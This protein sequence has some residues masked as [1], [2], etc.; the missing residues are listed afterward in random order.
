M[1]EQYMVRPASGNEGWLFFKLTPEKG[2]EL[3]CIGHVRM[4]FGHG[5]KEFW[6]TWHPHGPE[7]WNSTEFKAELT[8][9]VDTLRENVLKDL[10][11]MKAYCH[12]NGGGINGGWSQNY[13]YIVETD[14]YMYCLRCNPMPGDYQA[15]LTC[16]DR[17]VQEMNRTAMLRTITQDELEVMY[18]KHILFNHGEGGEKADFTNC[19]LTN[20]DLQFMQLNGA[21]FDDALL[22]NVKMGSAGVCFGSF[23]KTRFVQCKMEGIYAEEANFSG[24]SFQDCNMQ[25]G[26]YT[27]SNFAN[28]KF[29][30]TELWMADLPLCCIEGSSI[31]QN[32]TSGLNLSGATMKE[33][34][35]IMGGMV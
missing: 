5:G 27:H 31:L 10:P 32:D 24:A 23:Q 17:Q 1:K 7:E 29:T 20:L 8:Q 6:H 16:F 35:W 28:T 18:A 22:E 25:R 34:E 21:I 33:Q 12:Q 26:I 9:V 3:G 2:A 11:S 30:N 13:G 4:D 15:Y 14:R 19:R